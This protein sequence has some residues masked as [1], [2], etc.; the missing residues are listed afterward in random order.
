MN[1]NNITNCPKC[2]SNDLVFDI[3]TG[4][5]KCNYC[6]YY[7]EKTDNIAQTNV[8]DLNKDI[9]HKG[10]RNINNNKTNTVNLKCSKCGVN[11]I[12]EEK[13]DYPK[14]HW[15][16]GDL[17]ISQDN[18]IDNNDTMLPFVISKDEAIE[19]VRR[20]LKKRKYTSK[21]FKDRTN[22]ESI[23][24]IYVPYLYTD[25]KY[26]CTFNGNGEREI[27]YHSSGDDLSYT[28]YKYYLERNFDLDAKNIIFEAKNEV[29]KDVNSLI[30]NIISATSP[31]DVNER[32]SLDGK[33][34]KN[35]VADVIKNND[36]IP[37]E[38]LE[39]KLV[40]VAKC[41]ILDDIY[42]YNRG[43]KWDR[44]DIDV[45][46]LK[47]YYVYLPIWV[48]IDKEKVKN[49]T[50]Y[51][52]IAVN[53]RTKECVFHIPCDKKRTLLGGLGPSLVVSSV[54]TGVLFFFFTIVAFFLNKSNN[55]EL[56][57]SLAGPMATTV[58]AFI[59]IFII[60]MLYFYNINKTDS[61]GDNILN[62]NEANVDYEVTKISYKNER[63][64]K[65]YTSKKDDIDGV[66]DN[67][68]RYRSQR[69]YDK[70]ETT[71]IEK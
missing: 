7:I 21:E 47:S 6:G 31:F 13:D 33:Y 41:A 57:D 54:I 56:L 10:A 15:C 52:Y 14:C 68:D 5:I 61:L 58:C 60:T 24:G 48:I 2:S 38:D 30:K 34:F 3:E 66:N 65:R 37:N 27:D 17:K 69:Y 59:I 18:F 71:V 1:S 62:E 29:I 53:G 25:A 35:N 43:V 39:N 70:M 23:I 20:R 28:I 36:N 16:G 40:D 49:K 50:V 67:G 9:V 42:F 64:G 26:Q 12:S 4:K 22:P 63:L 45:K 46:E 55:N 44:T 19:V 51:Y 8:S 32:V 11:F